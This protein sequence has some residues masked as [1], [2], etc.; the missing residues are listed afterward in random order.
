[1]A[2]SFEVVSALLIKLLS[3]LIHLFPF[4]AKL[5]AH[6]TFPRAMMKVAVF[7]G[8]EAV[9]SLRGTVHC[10]VAESV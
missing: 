8:G 2:C 1:M 10:A 5:T 6:L 4:I 3:A 9:G 7:S